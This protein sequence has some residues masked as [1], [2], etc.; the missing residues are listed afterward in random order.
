MR[1]ERRDDGNCFVLVG[2]VTQA[3]QAQKHLRDGGVYAQIIKADSISPK[4]G[5]AYALEYSYGSDGDVRRIL[6]RA[7]IVAKGVH[8]IT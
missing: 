6:R 7:G 8:K 4:Y 1:N 5:C 2:S 3:I